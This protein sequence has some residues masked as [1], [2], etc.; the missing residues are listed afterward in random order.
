M[1]FGGLLDQMWTHK[2]LRN[3]DSQVVKSIRD[4]TLR[5]ARVARQTPQLSFLASTR[6]G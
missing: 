1:L 2:E 5:C 4:W 6:K 3:A